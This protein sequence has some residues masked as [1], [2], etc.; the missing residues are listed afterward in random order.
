MKANQGVAIALPRS[1]RVRFLVVGAAVLGL[2]GRPLLAQPAVTRFEEI[3]RAGDSAWK[4]GR[5]P[6]ARTRYLEAVALDSAGSSRAV[7]R[8]ATLHAWDGQLARAIPL[9]QR[10]AVLEPRDEEGRI[11]LAKALAWNGETASAVAI[12]DSILGRDRTYRDA[13]LGAAQ[14]LAW[15]GG[16]GAALTRY[17]RWLAEQPKDVE[18]ELARARTLAW[19]GKLSQAER[20]Y[21]TIAARGERLEADKGVAVVAA[22]RGDLGRS[23]RLWRGITARIPK[24]GEAWVGLAQVLRWS[25]RPHQARQALDR[26][27]A[28]NPANPDAAEQLRWVRAD[29]APAIEPSVTSSWDSDQNRSLLI[30]S[31]G[32][33]W[34]GPVQATTFVS[35]RWADLAPATGTS[36]SGRVSFRLPV[37]SGV[38]LVGDVGAIRIRAASGLLA[39][40]HDLWTGSIAG[41]A[42]VTSGLSVGANVRRSGFDET[43]L[44]MLS[45]VEVTS[46]GAEAEVRVSSR[47]GA[48]LGGDVGRLEGGSVLNRRRVGFASLRWRPSR[49]FAVTAAG[50]S[51]GYDESPRDGY[52]APERFRHGELGVRWSRG[53]DLGWNLSVDA[54]LGAQQVAFSSASSTKGTQRIAAGI[55]YRPA[56]G[57]EVA[58]DYSFSNVAATGAGPTGGGSIYRAQLITVR[59]KLLLR[60]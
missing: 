15:S 31:S 10:Y 12:Y 46:F 9:Y 37:G 13:A 16:F 21:Q 8:L 24:D 35:E 19:A 6:E 5:F 56:P 39:K 1:Y 42:R 49:G 32:R 51:L 38:G 40:A 36:T 52:F 53:R 58:A 57:F 29:L 50:R 59:G 41:T 2:A 43:A 54:G 45:G 55:G 4:A 17:D 30:G 28:A 44:M 60:D 7:F 11:A 23:E 25:G 27:L 22:W 47:I 20:A 48:A 33:G 18:A 3:V 14:A 26:A 34:L